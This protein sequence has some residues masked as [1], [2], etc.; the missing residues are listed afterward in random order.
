M[1]YYAIRGGGNAT[2]EEV[3]RLKKWAHSFIKED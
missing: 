3:L 2:P 1:R